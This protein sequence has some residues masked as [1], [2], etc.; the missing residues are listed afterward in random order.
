[1]GQLTIARIKT[2][3]EPGRYVDGDGLMLLVKASGAQSWVL[4][5]RIKGDRRDIGLGSTKVMTLSEARAKATELRR[6]IAQGFDPIAEK[7]K[8]EDPVPTFA[9]AARRVHE[10]QKASWKNGKHR[11][12]WITTLATYAFPFLSDRFVNAI[13]GPD[14]RKALLP[15]WLS[16]PETARRVRQRVGAVLAALEADGDCS[17]TFL[18]SGQATR[19]SGALALL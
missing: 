5:V 17:L 3:R 8:V 9:D 11:V 19:A 14:I 2:L 13:E 6:Q 7:K 4:R 10:E 1:M 16:K 18:S 15:I 12:Q